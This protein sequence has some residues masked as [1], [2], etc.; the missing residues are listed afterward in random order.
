MTT[1]FWRYAGS[2]S[3]NSENTFVDKG[4]IAGYAADAVDWSANNGIVRPVSGGT[5]A[6]KSSATRAQ[7][8]DALMNFD[9]S[10][11]SQSASDDLLL[12]Q[13]GTFTMGSPVS[14]PERSSDEV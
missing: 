8:A 11:N 4:E 7:V 5:F 14:E 13:G 10:R 1:I 12:I 6:P 3:A 9:R 2:P